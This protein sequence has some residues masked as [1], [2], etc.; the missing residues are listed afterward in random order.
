MGFVLPW[1]SWM[2]NELRSF[3][4]ESILSLDHYPAFN[5]TR[6]NSLW[7]NF[8]NGNP[9]ANWIQVWSLVVLGKWTSINLST[10]NN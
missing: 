9:K 8:L 4:E 3:C 7:K 6:V 5:M 10:K 1:E 2:K